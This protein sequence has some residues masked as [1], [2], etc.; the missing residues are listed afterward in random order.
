MFSEPIGTVRES[1]LFEVKWTLVF[2]QGYFWTKSMLQFPFDPIE[3]AREIEK[4]VTEGIQRKYHRFRK[5]LYYGGIATADAVGCLFL[6]A[7]CW[8]YYRNLDPQRHG[9]LY[10]PDEVGTILL[11]IIEKCNFT[12]AR[13][14]GAEPIL[15][16]DSFAHLI[17]VLEYVF[18]RRPDIDFILETNGFLLGY[19]PQLVE[20][21][22]F[23]NL[24]IRVA[25]KGWDEESFEKI[26]GVKREF[27]IYPLIGVKKM[28]DEGLSPWVAIMADIFGDKGRKMLQK[29]MLDLK[30]DCKIEQEVLERYPYVMDNMKKREIRGLK[31]L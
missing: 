22:K 6:C 8:S 25:I 13:I 27:F 30:I 28:L 18:A 15:G 29:R 11:D 21:L 14:T 4:I 20:R 1:V 7:Y 17:K 2:G 24:S 5:A 3:R 23:P 26:T 10:R 19:D 12:K 16:K 31:L 9:K